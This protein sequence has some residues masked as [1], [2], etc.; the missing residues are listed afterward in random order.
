MRTDE[1]IVLHYHA[2]HENLSIDP[3][4]ISNLTAVLDYSLRADSHPIAEGIVSKHRRLVANVE[5]VT[6][7]DPRIYGASASYER[8][9][10]DYHPAS[11]M[12]P[13]LNA[14]DRVWLDDRT[15]T[16]R[17]IFIDN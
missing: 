3:H 12:K 14:E 10:P 13:V 8:A 9:F 15:F 11:R 5:I 1:N 2:L 16:E 6:R 4:V 17:N 7:R